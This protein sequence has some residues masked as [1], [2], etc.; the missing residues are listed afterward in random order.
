MKI[1]T[2]TILALTLFACSAAA[3]NAASVTIASTD[4]AYI[5]NAN[6][7]NTPTETNFLVGQT[8]TASDHLR[9]LFTF[10]LT[11][12]GVDFSQVTIDSVTI[13]LT[14]SREDANSLN[15]DVALNLYEL[16]QDYDRASTTW[17]VA[18]TGTAWTKPG[19]TYDSNALLTTVS[20]NPGAITTGSTITLS[21][22][23]LIDVVSANASG[24]ADFILKL[25]DENYT[26]REIFFFANSGAG[27]P[28]IT[29]N[30][31]AIPE[32]SSFGLLGGAL[33]LAILFLGRRFKRS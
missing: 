27:A 3:L 20:A 5:R 15:S 14:T 29:I 17:T 26:N 25:A 6:A 7:L 22:Q 13:T 1:K 2:P 24:S 11:N 19:G 16:T 33:G 8:T 30:Y 9:G 32:A 21:G 28:T 18:E 23:A 12:S 10:D 4:G 31:T